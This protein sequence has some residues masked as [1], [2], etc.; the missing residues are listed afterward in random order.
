[1]IKGLFSLCRVRKS[2]LNFLIVALSLKIVLSV[3][4][5]SQYLYNITGHVHI[6][7]MF[8][9]FLFPVNIMGYYF[10]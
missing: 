4:T 3:A 5:Y 8:S 1:M 6:S 7:C 10:T 9:Y 2:N